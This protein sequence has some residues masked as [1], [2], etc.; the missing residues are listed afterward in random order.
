MDNTEND[1]RPVCSKHV[2]GCGYS[3]RVGDIVKIDGPGVLSL[4]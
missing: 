4:Y 1:G 3:A 2:M